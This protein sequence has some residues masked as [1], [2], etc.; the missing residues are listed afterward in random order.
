MSTT[1]SIAQRKKSARAFTKRWLAEQGTEKQQ[2]QTFWIELL[3]DVVG[4]ANPTH[5]IFFEDKTNY[6]GYI[7]AKMPDVKVFIEQ[8][9]R[10]VDL[11]KKELRQGHEVTPFEQARKYANDQKNSERPD[12]IVVCNFDEF[13]IHNLDSDFPETNYDSFTLSELADNLSLLDFLADPTTQRRQREKQVSIEAG[14]LIAELYDKLRCQYIDPDSEE[15]THPLNVLA[16][17]LVFCLYAEDAEIFPKNALHDLLVGKTPND[18]R[19]ALLALFAHLNTP[20]EHQDKYNTDL[21]PFPYVNG[22][23]FADPV[24]IPGL[25]DEIVQTLV[26]KVSAGTDWSKISPTIFGGV[27]ESTLNPEMRRAGGMHYTSPEYIHRVIDPLFLD[28]LTA[29]LDEIVARPHTGTRTRALKT[30]HDKLA[31][32]TFFDPACG[33]GNFLTETYICLRRLEN[34]VLAELSKGQTSLDVGEV[35]QLKVSIDQLY[36]IEINDFA[37][38]VANT[39]LWIAEIQAN[40]ETEQIILRAVENLPLR[41]LTHIVKGNALRIDWTDVLEPPRCSFIVGNPPFIG[42]SWHNDEQKKD[43]ASLFGKIKILDYVAGWYKKAADFMEDTNCRAALVS[44]NSITQ[45]QQVKPLW[46]PLFERGIRIN[47][48]HRTFSWG[49]ETKFGAHVHVVI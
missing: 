39:A 15:S 11:D 35:S 38:S 3:A 41:S 28:E 14:E 26:E 36:G 47:F 42:S 29:E 17:R 31:S 20:P 49:T 37:V 45:G 43:R 34:I 12:W 22:G 30:F 46:Q 48:A 8:K 33:S 7:D 2:T 10:G 40:L 9:S 6:N 13:R 24:E 19:S 21:A 25:T 23:L 16:V 18:A 27:F 32:L 5:H 4:V 1:L 44:T